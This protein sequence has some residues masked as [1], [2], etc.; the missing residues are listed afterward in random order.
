MSASNNQSYDLSIEQRMYQF[1]FGYMAV[2]AIAVAAKLSDAVGGSAIYSKKSSLDLALRG[3][4]TWCQHVG[5]QRRTLEWVG[6]LLLK[7]DGPP[8]FPI[9]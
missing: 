3:A 7:S 4:E 9:L 5:F 6:G 1:I 8:P 2:P